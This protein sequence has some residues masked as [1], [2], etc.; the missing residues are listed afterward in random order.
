M[1]TIRPAYLLALTCAALAAV[2]AVGLQL[3]LISLT[4]PASGG[5]LLAEG[6]AM[7]EWEKVM[8]ALTGIESKITEIATKA[9][10]QAKTLGKVDDD[11][12]AALKAVGDE[13]KGLAER[14]LQLEQKGEIPPKQ[15][16]KAETWGQQFLKAAATDHE[17]FVRSNFK[18]GMSVTLK[19]TLTGSDTTVAPAR[20]GAIVGGAFQPLM[21]EDFLPKV[22]TTSNAIEFTKENVFTNNAAETAEGAAKPESSLTWT[23]VNMPVATVAHWI[24][25]SKQLAA[26]AP[27]LAAYV[28]NRMRYGVNLRVEQQLAV[29][30]GTSPN[31]SGFMDT[32]NF[33]AHGY[34]DA[35]LGGLVGSVTAF[36]KLA[37]I[38]KMM[39]DLWAAGYP[40]DAIVM[41][42]AE[43]AGIE[44]VLMTTAA[45]QTLFSV[46]EGGTPRLFGLPVVQAI[47]MAADT[48]A[49]GAFRQAVVI[50]EREGVTVDMSESDSD[51]FT[52][53]LITIRAERRLALVT[54]R[55]A[56]I[57][58]GD[59]T[60]A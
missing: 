50:H 31:I 27:A 8:K 46:G 40:P 57:R 37:L 41:N 20:Q 5:F 17:A 14:L 35:T 21:L 49:V 43:W 24:K 42:P 39:A 4:E 52:K 13:Q 29:G 1:Q 33:T 18:R 51:N 9:E 12:K 23:L 16:E 28:D 44:I 36:K 11:T 56:A 34:S 60:P 32:G 2:F 6:I 55:P 47:G 26:D 3:D 59:I 53:N 48:V 54:E 10:G 15:T 7:A 45:G 38:R 22:P 30:D 58:A 19:N 25:I